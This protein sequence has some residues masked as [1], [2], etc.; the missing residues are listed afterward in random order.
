MKITVLKSGTTVPAPGDTA[1]VAYRGEVI[2]LTESMIE[3]TRDREGKTILDRPSD[4]W[5][6][7]EVEGISLGE[8]DTSFVYRRREEDLTAARGIADPAERH[9]AVEA[10][11][12]KYGRPSTST[13][14]GRIPEGR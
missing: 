1:R 9:A 8:D 10:V 7:G 11:H 4:R 6:E 12:T 2:E 3:S 5:I 13:S 14:L